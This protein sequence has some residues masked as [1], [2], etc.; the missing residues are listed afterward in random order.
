MSRGIEFGVTLLV[1]I[2]KLIITLA[3]SIIGGIFATLVFKRPYVSVTPA[4]V[5]IGFEALAI[6]FALVFLFYVAERNLK[7][8]EPCKALFLVFIAACWAPF[9][10]GVCFAASYAVSVG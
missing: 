2:T 5:A 1:D 7:G 8:T 3:T 10:T 9:L 6:L 4:E